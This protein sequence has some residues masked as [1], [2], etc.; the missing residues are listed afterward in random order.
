MQLTKL[1]AFAPDDEQ[2]A[3]SWLSPRQRWA[4]TAP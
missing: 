1:N 3:L 2:R 4:F